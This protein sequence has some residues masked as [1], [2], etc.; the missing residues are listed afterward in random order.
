MFAISDDQVI[1]I[2]FQEEKMTIAN[3]LIA[4]SYYHKV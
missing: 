1:I 2:E 4:D 3:V